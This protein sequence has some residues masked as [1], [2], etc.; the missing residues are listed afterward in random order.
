ML[1]RA[2]GEAV[3]I[4][5]IIAGGLGN[6]LVDPAQMETALLNLSINARDA[7]KGRGKL[8]IEAGNASLDDRYTALNVEVVPGQYVMLAVSDTGTGI[9]PD[10]VDKV[11]DPFFTTKPEGKGTGL[12]LSMV[13]G[14]VKQSG[15]HIKIY[16]EVGQ[17][18]AV[19]IYLPRNRNVEDAVDEIKSGP[20][21]GGTERILVVEDDND[22]RDT[23]VGILSELG[24]EI[25][26][27]RNAEAALAIIES[28]VAINVLFTD[29]VMPGK[30]QSADLARKARLKLPRIA[31][32]FTSGYANGAL[33]HG[34]RLDVGFDLI[35][36]PYSRDEIANKLR[37]VLR[38]P[39]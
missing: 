5:T 34:G 3:E 25:L 21:V 39:S 8:T 20:A 15:G 27:A 12:G 36:K 31:V 26:Q 23:V 38:R 11:F 19:R 10:L 37:Q 22:V 13:H 17:G 30:L 14:F 7:M 4:E 18:T 2:L 1:R 33:D 9:S 6:V 24:Y 32:L 16:T 29:V 28:G 35:S